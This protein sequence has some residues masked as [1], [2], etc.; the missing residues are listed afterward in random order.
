MISNPVDK[1]TFSFLRVLYGFI[2]FK[3]ITMDMISAVIE[4]KRSIK[5]QLID[6][7]Q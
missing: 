4:Y 2:E 5:K 6:K 3:D 7:L 1:K